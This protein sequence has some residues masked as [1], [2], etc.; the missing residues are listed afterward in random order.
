MDIAY[1]G[2]IEGQSDWG[3]IHFLVPIVFFLDFVRSDELGSPLHEWLSNK[4]VS[5][6]R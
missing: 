5:P 4:A 1:L 2:I 6:F 3:F